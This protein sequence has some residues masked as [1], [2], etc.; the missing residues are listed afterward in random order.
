MAVKRSFPSLSSSC[1][2]V[3]LILT[4]GSGCGVWSYNTGSNNSNKISRRKACRALITTSTLS[5]LCN[6]KPSPSNADVTNKIAGT[7]ALRSLTNTRRQL[8]AKLQPL[9]QSNNYK[10]IKTCLRESPFTNLRKDMLTIVRGGEDGQ[11]ATELLLA[12]KQ[13]INALET[14]DGTSTLGM[15][16]GKVDNFQLSIEYDDI[17]KALDLFIYVG[18]EAAGI[19]LQEDSGQMKIGGIDARSGKIEP[20]VL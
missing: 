7:T 5:I 12:Y 1:I 17:E 18:Y 3:I 16:R 6:V 10:G 19:P 15:Q 8:S 4:K 13:L 9:A 20:R 11:K 2:I 14:I